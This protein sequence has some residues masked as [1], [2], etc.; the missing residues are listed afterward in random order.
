MLFMTLIS[1]TEVKWSE[2]MAGDQE[3]THL[4]DEIENLKSDKKKLKASVD[5]QAKD[6][7]SKEKEV[8][9]LERET[10]NLIQMNR[11]AEEKLSQAEAEMK[12][13]KTQVKESAC[14]SDKNLKEKTN[15]IGN[16]QKALDAVQ[17]KDDSAIEALRTELNRK[18]TENEDL[19]Y[20]NDKLKSDIDA[21]EYDVKRAKD[22]RENLMSHYEQKIKKITEDL[23]L[24]RRETTKMREIMNNATPR[25]KIEKEKEMNMLREELTKKSE[26]IKT[27]AAKVTTPKRNNTTE[28][29]PSETE[30]PSCCKKLKTDHEALN[31]KHQND[32][33]K[34]QMRYE[35]LITEFKDT[36]AELLKHVPASAA[37]NVMNKRR[38][39]DDSE[40]ENVPPPSASKADTST[41]EATPTIQGKGLRGKRGRK[42]MSATTQVSFEDDS[43][44]TSTV[45]FEDVESSSLSVNEHD[46]SK[47]K[48]PRRGARVSKAT[49]P[50]RKYSSR[51][52]TDESINTTQN[53]TSN[54][55]SN[56]SQPLADSSSNQLNTI[57]EEV[58]F[59]T[60][61]NKKRKLFTNTPRPDVSS[62]RN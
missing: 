40:D 45:H 57:S 4:N 12:M 50:S 21:R 10:K 15:I 49:R 52:Q 37:K 24:E 41:I 33:S 43:T 26:L 30:T 8:E 28:N 16:L 42:K 54:S 58:Y 35:K 39:V 11:Q 31:E 9:N 22:D 27:L 55:T 3:I 20:K 19:Q 46:E 62:K 14:T 6:I 2:K 38:T 53:S 25:K 1:E 36:N 23:S 47:A 56:T 17:Q 5:S 51:S 48:R 7:T 44:S 60:P 13:L 59:Q 32:L 34:Q 18:H 61:S 29:E